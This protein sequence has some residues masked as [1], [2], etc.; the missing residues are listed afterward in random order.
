MGD[1]TQKVQDLLVAMKKEERFEYTLPSTQLHQ[2]AQA[3]A[4]IKMEPAS[5]DSAQ[6]NR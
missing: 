2:Q 6:A 4:Q 5:M 1:V 3:V